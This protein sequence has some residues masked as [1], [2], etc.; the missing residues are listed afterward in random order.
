MPIISRRARVTTLS[1][2]LALTIAP[3]ANHSLRAAPQDPP[4]YP[5]PGQPSIV[6][7]VAPGAAPRAALRYKVAPSFKSQL[8]MV[9]A[10]SMNMDM[11]GTQMPMSM[12]AMKM[13]ADVAVTAV[14]PTGDITYDLVFSDMTI[15]PVGAD[16]NVVTAMQGAMPSMK[17]MKGTA[18]VTSRGIQKSV[19]MDMAT[20]NPALQQTMQAMSSS[21]ENMSLPFPEEP[22]GVGAKWEVKQ[23]VD[24]GGMKTFQKITVELVAIQGN[25]VTLGVKTEQTAPPQ[26]VSN[27]QLPAGATMS[28]VSLTGTGTGTMKLKL[29]SLVPNSEMNAKTSTV[30]DMS[31]GGSSQRMSVDT[32]MK[33]TIAPPKEF[34]DD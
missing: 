19:N 12:P 25:A 17:G 28:L 5:A 21:L 20:V 15:D 16:P 6:T 18:V 2:L 31:M 33:V 23:A 9:M 26:P 32:T 30:M 8:N 11:G 3:L 13:S 29:D 4:G 10:M 14:S 1:A 24:S 34:G 7:L 27:P 22:I